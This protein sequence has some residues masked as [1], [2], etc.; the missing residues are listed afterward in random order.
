MHMPQER[1]IFLVKIWLS[2]EWGLFVSGDKWIVENL[3]KKKI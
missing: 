3:L 2:V 1:K